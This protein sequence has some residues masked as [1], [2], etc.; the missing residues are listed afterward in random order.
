VSSLAINI[1]QNV[2]SIGLPWGIDGG[3]LAFGTSIVLFVGVSLMTSSSI[4]VDDDIDE[5]MKI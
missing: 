2:F 5:M 4:H 3:F 1:I